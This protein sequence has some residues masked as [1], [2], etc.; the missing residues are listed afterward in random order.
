MGDLPES[1]LSAAILTL[2]VRTPG[3]NGQVT[4]VET[5]SGLP[6]DD[7]V[8]GDIVDV[9][10]GVDVSVFASG[11][12][13]AY[14]LVYTTEGRIYATD[15]GPNAGFG[16]QSTG[17]DSEGEDPGTKD[18][19]VLIEP[20][21]YYGHPNRN[22]GRTDA[23]Q[24]VY[25]GPGAPEVPGVYSK[26][27]FELPSSTD[28]IV[29]YRAQTFKGSMRG[30]LLVQT[31]NGGTRRLEMSADGRSVVSAQQFVSL[32]SLALATGPG[33]VIFSANHSGSKVEMLIPNDPT[34]AE[35]VTALDITPW[36]APR[37]AARDFVIAGAGFGSLSD[38]TVTIGGLPATLTSVT[39][40]RIR[41]VLPVP[42]SLPSDLVDVIVD[43]GGVQSVLTRAFRFLP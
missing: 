24:N 34:L 23:I 21:V 4:Y 42:A 5:A 9:A 26:N 15:N 3:F 12:R 31:W 43:V 2:P 29:E 18:E 7:Q 19:I 22:R 39:P 10:P 13:N 40:T 37:A 36:R 17:P 20:G 41:G 35:G 16:P 25:H 32:G 30:N 27:L 14:D 8:F 28:G 6:N 38:T 1:P 11:L 33:G